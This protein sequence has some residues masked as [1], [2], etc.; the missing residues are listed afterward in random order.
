M[1]SVGKLSL[2]VATLGILVFSFCPLA[3]AQAAPAR[4]G[5]TRPRP[6]WEFSLSACTAAEGAPEGSKRSGRAKATGRSLTL[7]VTTIP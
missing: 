1:N 7:T 2:G 5:G 3:R 6:G 4:R